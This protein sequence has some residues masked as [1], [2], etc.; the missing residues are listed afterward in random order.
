MN[1]QHYMQR[2]I[3]LAWQG[4]YSTSPNPRVGCVLVRD[5]QI[6]GQ[7]FHIRAGQGHAE[8]NAL[9]DCANP[10]QT[11]AY[12]T[13]EPCNH[14][15]KTPPCTDALIKAQVSR[16]V[17]AMQDPNPA[18]AG[19]GIAKL[20]DAGIQVD[21]GVLEDRAKALNPG[22]IQRMES[23]KPY[24]TVKLAMSLDGRTA[25]AN[26][27]SQWIT[28]AAARSDVQRLRARSC[29]I[30][31]GV[32]TVIHDDASLT[33]RAEQL[34]LDSAQT[35]L[36][37][38]QQPLRVVLDSHLRLA[39]TAKILSQP[40]NTL[41]VAI[42]KDQHRASS[43]QAAGAE[44]VYLSADKQRIDL[45]QLMTFLANRQCNEVLVE[46]GATLAGAFWQQGLVN[47][48]KVYMAPTLMGSE[49]RA[50]L[51]LPFQSMDQQQRLEIDSIS[52][53]GKDWRIDAR[54]VEP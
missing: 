44:V 48:L 23:G 11:T 38:E 19:S 33:V 50:L 7:G 42:N 3:D 40:G 34:G 29:A 10:K 9:T 28:G 1:D 37:T 49:A 17:V 25:M 21:V 47:L 43:L 36:A 8:V 39:P 53:L 24:V 46:A 52:P 16:V 31:S 20:C 26:G 12:V 14:T 41:V 4:L 35:C 30:V 5:G 32:D 22:F 51:D 45:K 13:L 18:V 6:V 15:G 27:E 54:P 2:A